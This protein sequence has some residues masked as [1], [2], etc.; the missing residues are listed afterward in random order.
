MQAASHSLRQAATLGAVLAAVV[1]CYWAAPQNGYVWDDWFLFI[2]NPM[3][4]LEHL[5]WAT[6][7]AP[8]MDGTTYFRPMVFLSFWAEFHFLG[9]DAAW[10]HAINLAIHVANVSLIF[11]IAKRHCASRELEQADV[12]AAI[13]ASLYG[14]HPSLVE[15]VA[16]VSGRFDLLATLF[17]VLALY[18]DGRV[19]GRYVRPAVLAV[20]FAGTLGSKEIGVVL[21]LALL[22]QRV[23]L[24]SRSNETLWKA[25]GRILI[26]DLAT[27]ITL[28]FVLLGYLVLRY[29]SFDALLHVNS[30]LQGLSGSLADRLLLV[31]ATFNFHLKEIVYPFTSVGPLHPMEAAELRGPAGAVNVLSGMAALTVL[32]YGLLKRAAPALM[33]LS[34]AIALLPVL[35]IVPLTIANNIGCDRF[36]TLPLVFCVL[37]LSVIELRSPIAINPRLGQILLPATIGMWTVCA[38]MITSSFVL[39]W[40]SDFTLWTW[41]YRQYPESPYARLQVSSAAVGAHRFDIAEALFQKFKEEGPLERSLQLNYGGLL[42]SAGDRDEGRKYL[43]GALLAFPQLHTMRAE[44]RANHRFSASASMDIAFAYRLLAIADL[45]EG[46]FDSALRNADISVWYKPNFPVFMVIKALALMAVDRL[47]EGDQLFSLATELDLPGN[48]AFHERDRARFIQDACTRWPDRELKM[49]GQTNSN[50][51]G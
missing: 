36:L 33:L 10:S 22:L 18:A 50:E 41:A 23:L 21:P 27:V 29:L 5:T 19:R 26:E 43:E 17:V 16:W 47:D 37:G 49:C 14:L 11:L 13:A 38:A 30:H 6:L 51:G 48:K 39:Q 3:L 15:A 40:K 12:R 9:V 32:F 4:R 20:L 8:V 35:N 31:I 25:G 24:D 34:A 44:E 7:S 45:E 42:I 28:G 2:H 1:G 46:R